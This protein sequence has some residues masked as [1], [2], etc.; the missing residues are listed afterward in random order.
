MPRSFHSFSTEAKAYLNE[1]YGTY[2]LS[3]EEGFNAHLS[4]EAKELSSDEL[5]QLLE[6]KHIS[7][8][9]P[10]SKD[11]SQA[12]DINNTYLEDYS[13]NRSRGAQESTEEEIEIALEDQNYDVTN[14]QKQ[15][16]NWDQLTDN[17]EA[18]DD[19][20]LEEVLGG[21]LL[22]GTILSGFE[23]S[24][25]IRNGEIAMSEAPKYYTYK[26]GGK[27]IRYAAI[28]LSLT[29]GSPI[30]VSAGVG[31]I[32]FKN[33]WLINTLYNKANTAI[34]SEPAQHALLFSK[35]TIKVA[36][37]KGYQALTSK[38]G[39][40]IIKTAS[41]TASSVGKGV[42]GLILTG[43]Y[44]FASMATDSGKIAK[45]FWQERKISQK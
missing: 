25:A 38:T 35:R 37:N 45:A 6:Q 8:I 24:N 32:L 18:W 40:K 43:L 16:T 15:D 36:G 5:I 19:N 22:A 34:S 12:G 30:I 44:S 33:R 2:G 27:T 42:G 29:S 41:N 26:T 7:H 28:G 20:L 9:V 14:I 17:L 31:Y 11:P 23:T 13:V 4:D 39:K 10:Q 3:G 1:R 21:S